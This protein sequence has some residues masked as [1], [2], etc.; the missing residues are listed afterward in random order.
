[1]K[2]DC[3]FCRI[4]EKL[5]NTVI[6][7]EDEECIAFEDLNKQAPV[8]FLVIPKK[9]IGSLND[10]SVSDSRLIGRIF[11]KIK[12]IAKKAE[13]SEG[14]YRIVANCNRDAGQEVFHLHFHVLG[15]RKFSW[16]P[17]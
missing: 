1:M 15:G 5:V 7:Y 14:G 10:I 11:C 3:I 9:H 12:E 2:D 13:I 6:V 16:P 17:G 4:A 8:H